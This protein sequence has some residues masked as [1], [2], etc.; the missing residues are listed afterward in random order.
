MSTNGEFRVTFWNAETV[1]LLVAKY[2]VSTAELFSIENI[3]PKNIEA[4]TAYFIS[5]N[6][7]FYYTFN[8]NLNQVFPVESGDF[9]ITHYGV[10]S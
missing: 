3:K 4:R 7:D 10:K 2:I 1:E 8:D 5:I 6:T 9:L